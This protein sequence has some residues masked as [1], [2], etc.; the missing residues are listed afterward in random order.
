MVD[1]F[2]RSVLSHLERYWSKI[3]QSLRDGIQFGSDLELM[4]SFKTIVGP[5]R[6][7]S[8]PFLEHISENNSSECDIALWRF[9]VSKSRLFFLRNY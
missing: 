1:I 2:V 3:H 8:E 5:V 4:E 9:S 7:I 6:V